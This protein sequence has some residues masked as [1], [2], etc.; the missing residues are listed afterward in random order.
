MSLKTMFIP[1][2][3]RGKDETMI[4]TI[5]TIVAYIFMAIGDLFCIAVFVLLI[6]TL[7][8]ISKSFD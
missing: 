7:W 8:A 1:A 6:A 5:M 3:C 2:K 4:N